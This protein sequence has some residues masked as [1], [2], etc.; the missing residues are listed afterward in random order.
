MI[1]VMWEIFE[2]ASDSLVGTNMQRAYVSTTNGR[3]NP[4]L[5]QAALSDTMKDLILDAAGA[6][7]MCSICGVAVYTNKIRLEDLSF[8]K[9]HGKVSAANHKTTENLGE[10]KELTNTKDSDP[11]NQQEVDIETLT[12]SIINNEH[13]NNQI[14]DQQIHDS[15]IE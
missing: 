9:K 7:I 15:S 8:I 4:L 14:S 10:L 5:G 6:A 13:T 2:F 1:G 12:Q 3:G 11:N